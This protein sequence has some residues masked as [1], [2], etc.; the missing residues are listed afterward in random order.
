MTTRNYTFGLVI[1]ICLGVIFSASSLA[2]ENDANSPAVD[3]NAAIKSM[4][5]IIVTVN[6][7]DITQEQI[8][9]EIA[10]Q[11]EQ[12]AKQLPPQFVE[13]Y[14]K[15][16]EAQIVDK[17]VVELLLD[18][19]VARDKVNITEEEITEHITQM[20][21]SQNPPLSVDDL[22]ALV[23]AGGR[24]FDEVKIRIK[25][26]MGYQKL[27]EKQFNDKVDVTEDEINKYYSENKSE[28]ETAEQVRVSHILIKLDADDPN[29]DPNQADVA[30]K[31][32]ADGLL[33]QIKDGA[34]FAELAKANSS[35]PSSAKGG[36]LNFFGKG[37]MVPE[38]EKAAFDLQPQQVGDVVKTQFGYH[39]IKVT[40]KKDAN[41]ISLEQAKQDIS[42]KLK[43]TKQ[44]KL[45]SDY[46]ELL[47]AQADI[48]YPV[49]EVEKTTVLVMPEPNEAAK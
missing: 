46:V 42:E 16:L 8:D 37:Q 12:M 40:D 19:K 26:G 49:K 43:Q 34:D 21:A 22:K 11:L 28:F 20:A 3:P 27:F 29:V 17:M 32:K 30:A 2:A 36:D 10:P 6:G 15:Q 13:Q 1:L 24:S 44:A 23:E 33:K 7:I 4:P 14:K 5:K 31:A 38:F 18:E 47:K 25:K 39:I 45:A 9:I 48:V 41:L 35:C